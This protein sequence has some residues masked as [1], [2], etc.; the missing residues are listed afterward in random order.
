MFRL[1]ELPAT[2]KNMAGWRRHIKDYYKEDYSTT[3]DR[4]IIKD[5]ATGAQLDP[6]VKLAGLVGN[7]EET[8]YPVKVKGLSTYL[9]SLIFK[10]NNTLRKSNE[11]AMRPKPYSH[12]FSLDFGSGSSSASVLSAGQSKE[13]KGMV[14]SSSPLSRPFPQTYTHSNKQSKK[15]GSDVDGRELRRRLVAVSEDTDTT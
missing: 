10:V 12:S 2:V 1:S 9:L 14:K 13:P 11:K 4:I 8:Q 7:S 3:A 6:A 5:K 15:N